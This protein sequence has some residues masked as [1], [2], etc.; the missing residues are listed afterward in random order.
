MPNIEV[1]EKP[2]FESPVVLKRPS[3]DYES[4]DLDI[5]AKFLK[6]LIKSVIK[7]IDK[8]SK[9]ESFERWK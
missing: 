4:S 7:K 1:K 8:K 3:D 2:K 9:R 5:R 6:L